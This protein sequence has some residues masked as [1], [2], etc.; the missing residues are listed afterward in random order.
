MVYPWALIQLSSSF[1]LAVSNRAIVAL[2]LPRS[3][4]STHME[5][6]RETGNPQDSHAYTVTARSEAEEDLLEVAEAKP[7]GA[8]HRTGAAGFGGC[9]TNAGTGGCP[10]AIEFCSAYMQL[11]AVP[12]ISESRTIDRRS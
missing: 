7:S 2:G 6:P 4:Q 12:T 9:A 10:S 8:C 3:S 11:M 1:C 5:R